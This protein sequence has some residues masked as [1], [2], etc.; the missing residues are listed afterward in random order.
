MT[1]NPG[2]QVINA[3]YPKTGTK[4]IHEAL[5]ILGHNV[6]DSQ[7]NVYSHWR[8]WN[9]V[10]TGTAEEGRK[11]IRKLYA[12]NNEFGYTAVCDT[13]TCAY[14]EVL[15]DECPDA[16]VIL[17]ERDPEKWRASLE[18]H[19]AVER[20]QFLEMWF[21]RCF[22][23]LYRFV[24]NHSSKPFRVY[25]DFIRPLVLGPEDA[26]FRKV[27]MDVCVTRYNQHNMY[28]KTKCPKDKLLVYRIGE[29]WE[30][31]CK[32][33]NKPVPKEPFPHVNRLGSVIQD[34]ANHPDYISTMKRQFLGWF[35][36]SLMVAGAYYCLK[37]N[38]SAMPLQLCLTNNL[39]QTVGAIVLFAFVFWK[40]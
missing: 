9:E 21:H 36:R 14:W 11:A 13:P 10:W 40:A 1:K 12:P 38:P 5:K 30:P 24:F 17:V 26:N 6:C 37:L 8:E 15:L 25:M 3:G 22:G 7:E 28:V 29:G 2:L 19:V 31:I 16:K 32:F 35:L 4:T 33:L 18:K 27:N 39:Y 23:P 20:A 34:L